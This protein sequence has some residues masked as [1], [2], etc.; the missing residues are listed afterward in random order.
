MHMISEKVIIKN[1]LGIHLRP[2]T[3][4]SG[5]ALE[6]DSTIEL[7]IANTTVNA[8]SVLGVLAAG[9]SQ[10]DEVEITC[11]GADELEALKAIIQLIKDGMGDN[12]DQ[13]S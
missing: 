5:K 4:L 11:D 6:F 7:K 13:K 2:A 8:K 9:V 12:I 3:L 1:K 10:A